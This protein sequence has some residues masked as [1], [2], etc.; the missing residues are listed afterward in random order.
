MT[1][2]QKRRRSCHHAAL[3]IALEASVFGQEPRESGKDL[4]PVFEQ[5]LP[6]LVN[7]GF[8]SVGALRNLE[9]QIA[10]VLY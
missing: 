3:L 7:A 9:T 6:R 2:G 5:E 4:Q 8:D 10:V 1:T